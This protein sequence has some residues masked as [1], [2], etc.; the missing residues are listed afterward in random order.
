VRGKGHGIEV[1][2]WQ[3]AQELLQCSG[4]NAPWSVAPN[5]SHAWGKT[6]PRLV[7]GKLVV[8]VVRHACD[9]GSDSRYKGPALWS[10]SLALSSDARQH[11]ERAELGAARRTGRSKCF[12]WHTVCHLRTAPGVGGIPGVVA[13]SVSKGNFR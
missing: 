9:R 3:D 4:G 10:C 12:Y 6:R 13:C 2:P 7:L 11:P 5:W 1:G 8:G